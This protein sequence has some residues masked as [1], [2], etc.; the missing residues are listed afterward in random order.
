MPVL[1][2]MKEVGYKWQGLTPSQRKVYQDL[3]DIDKVRYRNELKDFEKEVET[4]QVA[5]P[6][7]SKTNNKAK[8]VNEIKDNILNSAMMSV[9]LFDEFT[10]N[11]QQFLIKQQPSMDAKKAQAIIIEK[12]E[13]FTELERIKFTKNPEL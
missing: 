12:W 2:I 1:Q 3:A 13:S 8:K 10:K 9:P 5:K 11:W 4:L 6:L 7:K